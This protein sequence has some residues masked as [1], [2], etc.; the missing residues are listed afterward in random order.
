VVEKAKVLA[1]RIH[2]AAQQMQNQIDMNYAD[3]K[4]NL[5]K[6]NDYTDQMVSLNY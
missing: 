1:D 5:T 4:L 6:I 2:T 3:M